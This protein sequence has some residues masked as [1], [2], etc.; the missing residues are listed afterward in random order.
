MIHCK[1][2]LTLSVFILP[3]IVGFVAGW[4]VLSIRIGH[5]MAQTAQ[6]KMLSWC[7]LENP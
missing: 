3:M 7:E 6:E 5:A 2:L 1:R 4:F